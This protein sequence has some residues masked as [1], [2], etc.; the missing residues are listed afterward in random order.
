VLQARVFNELILV[1]IKIILRE[2]L[3]LVLHLLVRNLA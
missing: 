3:H 1:S 2:Y